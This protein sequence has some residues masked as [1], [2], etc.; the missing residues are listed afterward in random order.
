MSNASE[1]QTMAIKLAD[2]KRIDIEQDGKAR[3]LIRC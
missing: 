2:P 3:R 1:T